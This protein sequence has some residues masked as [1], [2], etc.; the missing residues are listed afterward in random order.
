M[1]NR[2]VLAAGVAA[3][4]LLGG[5]ATTQAA[6]ELH[7]TVTG[8]PLNLDDAGPEGRDTEAFKTFIETGK[9]PYNNEPNCLANGEQLYLGM[10][11]G[12]HGHVA[13]GKIGPGLNDNY[14]TYPDNNT[15]KGLFETIFGGASGQMGPMYGAVN[16]DQMLQIMAW[17]R[18]L[19][20]DG[21]DDAKWL[22]DA[23][24]A[25]F[26]PY[27]GHSHAPKPD[28]AKTPEACKVSE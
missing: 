10:C 27:D 14:W 28:P 11:S 21:V 26:K 4:A 22:D 15:D 2:I 8:E 24:K 16:P 12:C 19:Y 6:I 17:V 3:F 13:E 18:H 7:N 9:N 23:Q 25:S 5:P 20:K 1:I